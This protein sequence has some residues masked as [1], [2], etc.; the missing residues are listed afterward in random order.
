M[1][2]VPDD[3]STLIF[4][5]QLAF[6][7]DA[8]TDTD[9]AEPV[10]PPSSLTMDDL[11]R[12][13]NNPALAPPGVEVSALGAREY[14]F[15]QPDLARKVRISTNP[16]YYEQ[17]ADNVELWSPGNPTFTDLGHWPRDRAGACPR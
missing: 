8:V 3:R 12:V 1:R 14:A 9:L 17:N 5:S 15:Q 7:I 13:I 11:E 10:L 2:R 4:E 16:T 6:N